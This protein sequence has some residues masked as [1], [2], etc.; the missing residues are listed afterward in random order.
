MD[1]DIDFVRTQFP[2]FAE[3]SLQGWSFFENAGGSYACGQVIQALRRYYVETKVQPYGPYPASA[4]A[5]EAMD[6][7]RSRWA[8]ALGVGPG[9]VHFGPSTSMNCYVLANAF[10]AGLGPGDEVV[11]TNQ[12]HEANTGAVRRA[13][14]RAGAAVVE[15]RTDP[16]TGLLELDRLADLLS[17]KTRLVTVPHCSNIVGQ[18][19]DVAA[20]AELVHEVG[21]R[22]VVD[23]VSYAPHTLPD[24]AG[25]G[26]DVYLFSLYKTYSVHQGLMVT[27]NGVLDEL[28]NQGHGFNRRHPAKLLTPAGPDHA[29]EAAAGAVLDYV[30]ALHRHHLGPPSGLRAATAAVS[31]LWR[32]HEASLLPAV[33]ERLGSAGTVRLLG[34]PEAPPGGLHR[35]PTVA[36]VPLDRSPQEV[37]DRLA[38]HRIMCSSGHFYAYRVLQG[39]GIDPERGVVRLSWVHYT[40]AGDIARLLEALDDLLG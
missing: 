16:G 37:A 21:A 29:Q 20:I 8:Q 1:L 31:G 35:C 3:P 30:E 17:A 22:L 23:G 27:R 15:W 34:P 9:D 6:R 26:A 14:G 19:N 36:F 39:L 38:G 11:V 40:S 5:G 4:E 33:L 25:L 24:V 13:A 10:A 12:D 2:A 32:R 7:S 18:E 28:P